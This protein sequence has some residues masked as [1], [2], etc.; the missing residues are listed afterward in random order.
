MNDSAHTVYHPEMYCSKL[1][2]TQ[3]MDGQAQI[4]VSAQGV[5]YNVGLLWLGEGSCEP[6]W[7]CGVPTPTPPPCAMQDPRRLLQLV[8]L[9]CE[10]LIPAEAH[11]CR[12]PCVSALVDAGLFACF[13]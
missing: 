12:D 8:E 6:S 4:Y 11:A 13:L 1:Q 10:V 3:K 9:T 2:H 5:L 7:C